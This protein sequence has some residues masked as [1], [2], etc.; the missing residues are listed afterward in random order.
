MKRQ[1]LLL[2]SR[3]PALFQPLEPRQLLSVTPSLVAV[4]ISAA[5]IAADPSLAND[6]TFDLQVTLDKGERWLVADLD[7]KLSK[8]S[9][10][11]SNSQDQEYAQENLWQFVPQLQYDT[12]VTAGNWDKPEIL[13]SFKPSSE[14]AVF[15]SNEV[16]VTWGA[17]SD[18]GT[19]TVT[20]ARLT[21]SSDAVGTVVGDVASTKT[22]PG[23]ET[24]FNFTLVNVPLPSITGNVYSDTNGD[25]KLDNSETGISNVKVYL[26]KNDDGHWETGEKYTFT[27]SKGNY[28]F[29]PLTAG[30]YYVREELPSNYR[31]TQPSNGKWTCVLA[32]GTNG[33][34]K[35]FGD[36]P[37]VNISGTVFG[38]NNSNGK[39]DSGDG[40][41]S[42]WVI[43]IDSNNDGKLDNGENQ[44]QDQ[45]HR[46]VCLQQSQGW[47]LPHPDHE[48]DQLQ[49]HDLQQQHLHPGWRRREDRIAVRNQE[50]LTPV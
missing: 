42:G 2:S 31:R 20:I 4:P 38:D 10:Y 34:D 8:G 36:D 19:G 32:N 3:V 12:F 44:H 14:D 28:S 7:V 46:R 17:L 18:T 50:N 39:Q 27:D 33:T 1:R 47:N 22:E 21:V 16:N 45:F 37:R 13:G 25:G 29:N 11:E 41:A 24:Q 23:P 35:D 15:S 43:Y 9:F 48:H 26:D 30:T 40:G 49:D 5:A 6:K